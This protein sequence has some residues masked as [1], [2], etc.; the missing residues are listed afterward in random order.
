M[1]SIRAFH[2]IDGH[3]V[4]L[5]NSQ[6][7]GN[8]IGA[9]L[10]PRKIKDDD[11]VQTTNFATEDSEFWDGEVGHVSTFKIKPGKNS[12]IKIVWRPTN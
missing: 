10:I 9:G 11:M 5:T 8:K 7:S 6:G 3:M 2:L 4:Y 12:S 1:L